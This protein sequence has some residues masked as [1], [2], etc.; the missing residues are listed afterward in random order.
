MEY[1][2]DKLGILYIHGS[3]CQKALESGNAYLYPEYMCTPVRTE[4]CLHHDAIGSM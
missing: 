3:W 4:Q 1:D 2:D